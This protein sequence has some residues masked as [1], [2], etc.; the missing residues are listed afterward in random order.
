MEL[1]KV[2]DKELVVKEYDGKKVLTSY[3]IAD[4]HN[5]EVNSITKIVNNNLDR[6]IEKVDYYI[7]SKEKFF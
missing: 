2:K 3:D 5:R 1:V 4:I 6:L 7:I